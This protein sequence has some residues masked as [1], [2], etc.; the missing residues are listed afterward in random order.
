MRVRIGYL[1]VILNVAIAAIYYMYMYILKNEY[2]TQSRSYFFNF[3]YRVQTQG[4]LQLYPAPHNLEF[5][6]IR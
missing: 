1:N 4:K 6:I 3:F 5:T 2:M